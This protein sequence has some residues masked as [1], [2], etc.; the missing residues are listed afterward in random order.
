MANRIYGDAGI[1]ERISAFMPPALGV[2][3][4]LTGIYAHVNVLQ[5]NPAIAASTVIVSGIAVVAGTVRICEALRERAADK[6]MEAKVKRLDKDNENLLI[7]VSGFSHQKNKCWNKYNGELSLETSF[8]NYKI[9]MVVNTYTYPVKEM[10]FYGNENTVIQMK[11]DMAKAFLFLESMDGKRI[12]PLAESGYDWEKKGFQKDKFMKMLW[13]TE[14]GDLE[15]IEECRK[16]KDKPKD[17]PSYVLNMSGRK[18]VNNIE[19]NV[20]VVH[21]EERS[22]AINPFDISPDFE[23]RNKEKKR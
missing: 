4:I 6:N 12:E 21:N 3:T 11:S 10:S 1:W 20:T 9:K 7:D 15:A 22:M 17:V 13:I 8:E 19:E 5:T 14:T 23:E 2:A 18:I 16:A